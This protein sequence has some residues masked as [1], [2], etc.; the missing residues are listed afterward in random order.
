M[1]SKQ[2]EWMDSGRRW[3]VSYMRNERKG[4]RIK[5]SGRNLVL[6]VNDIGVVDDA[7]Y[8]C[9][10]LWPAVAIDAVQRSCCPTS[11]LP[12]NRQRQSYDD[13]LDRC[14]DENSRNYIVLLCMYDS[15]AQWDTHTNYV[16]S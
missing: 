5:G 11:S 7:R 15:C 8:I 4:E 12:S 3:E 10:K 16:R 6:V 1:E 14:Y 13:C 9:Y 2:S